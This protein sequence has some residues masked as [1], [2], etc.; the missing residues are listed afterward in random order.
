[1]NKLEALVLTKAQEDLLLAHSKIMS[2]TENFADI[3]LY[4]NVN[5]G[6]LPTESEVSINELF[7]LIRAN[8]VKQEEILNLLGNVKVNMAALLDNK[9]A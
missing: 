2:I 3:V 6:N 1:M 4:I 9:T 8:E 5:K 7:S